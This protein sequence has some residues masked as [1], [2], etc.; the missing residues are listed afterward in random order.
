MCSAC[1]SS[2]SIPTSTFFYLFFYHFLD[3]Y[4]LTELLFFSM[5]STF[6]FFHDQYGIMSC[7]TN[8]YQNPS[9]AQYIKTRSPRNTHVPPFS[10]V[11]YLGTRKPSHSQLMR[12]KKGRNVGRCKDVRAGVSWSSIT[13]QDGGQPASAMANIAIQRIKREFKEVIKSDEVS[14]QTSGEMSAGFVPRGGS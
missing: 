6:C 5:S 13:Q 8:S 12:Q 14:F 2:Y 3:P 10:F 9:C 4:F 11:E 7:N 1:T